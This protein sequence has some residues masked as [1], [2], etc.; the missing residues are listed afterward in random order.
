MST[1]GSTAVS[2]GDRIAPADIA[3]A[4]T[5]A[6]F[7]YADGATQ[8]FTPDGHT[9]YTEHGRPS[10]GG[11][12]VDDEGRFESFWPPSEYTIYQLSWIAGTD[13]KAVGIRF[14]DPNRGAKF[15]GRYA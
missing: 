1:T 5:R 2:D 7:V 8:V 3:A 12:K 4:L 13:G 15:D 14:T 11:W 10:S 6:P 9:V